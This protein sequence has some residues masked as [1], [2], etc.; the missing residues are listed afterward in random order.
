MNE[1]NMLLASRDAP[2]SGDLWTVASASAQGKRGSMEDSHS[3]MDNF[4]GM[5]D[6]L[7]VGVFDGH[8]G[9]ACSAFLAERMGPTLQQQLSSQ[10]NAMPTMLKVYHD[11]DHEWLVSRQEADGST[12]AN[13][14]LIHDRLYSANAG[15]SRCIVSVNGTAERLSVDHTPELE[16]ERLR[17]LSSFF[18]FLP[19]DR[20][21]ANG[22]S[23]VGGRLQ[24]KL[25]LSRGFGD[26]QFKKNDVL[27][28]DPRMPFV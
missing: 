23:V 1:Q 22:G 2:V 24:G 11:L 10:S 25:G 14:L 19:K 12:A 28:C 18:V 8:F 21:L 15:D 4:G 16:E 9:S 7:F 3:I 20:I 26:R 17:F 5:N 13:L 6:S 27:I